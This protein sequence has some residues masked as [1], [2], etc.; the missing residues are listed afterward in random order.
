MA[1]NEDFPLP[2]VIS[3]ITGGYIMWLVLKHTWVP[4]ERAQRRDTLHIVMDWAE[5][6]IISG[7]KPN[8]FVGLPSGNG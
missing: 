2:P 8:L 3:L 1:I 7:G 5:A 4:L 6:E